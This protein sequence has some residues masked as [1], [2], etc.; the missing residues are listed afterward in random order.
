MTKRF[1]GRWMSIDGLLLLLLLKL[2]L[3]AVTGLAAGVN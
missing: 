2:L 3:S 1:C